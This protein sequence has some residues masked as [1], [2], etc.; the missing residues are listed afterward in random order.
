MIHS[1]Y[2]KSGN[3]ETKKSILWSTT[4]TSLF[5][6]LRIRFIRRVLLKSSP[7]PTGEETTSQGAQLV[8]KAPRGQLDTRHSADKN[9]PF[10]LH[11]KTC[12][13]VHSFIQPKDARLNP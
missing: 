3:T 6:P 5:G 7:G 11:L 8:E 10:K 4:R 13:K 1:L 9:N 12:S 2:G